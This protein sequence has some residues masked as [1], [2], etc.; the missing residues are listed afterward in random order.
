M[1]FRSVFYTG[2]DG[3]T[4]D[5][6]ESGDGVLYIIKESWNPTYPV[7][8]ESC[9]DAIISATTADAI[10]ITGDTAA[11]STDIAGS[12]F[13]AVRAYLYFDTSDIP[14]GATI[15]SATLSLYI[16]GQDAG[17][18]GL[19]GINIWSG[20]PDYPSESGGS[21][22]LQL[23][24]VEAAKYSTIASLG[25]FDIF[26]HIGAILKREGLSSAPVGG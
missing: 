9:A 3:E 26:A 23:S 6:S 2:T 10:S 7:P 1:L 25:A 15:I 19:P 21:P 22:A 18:N 11:L 16:G 24:D 5:Y 13:S 8:D 12:T 4:T 17:T 14:S 20:Q